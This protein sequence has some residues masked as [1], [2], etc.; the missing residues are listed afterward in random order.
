MN[1]VK[2]FDKAYN[3]FMQGGS[4]KEYWKRRNKLVIEFQHKQGLDDFKELRKDNDVR[5]I[6]GSDK[7]NVP[8]FTIGLIYNDLSLNIPKGIVFEYLD[9]CVEGGELSYVDWYKLHGLD[10][11]NMY[12][13]ANVDYLFE[14][15]EKELDWKDRNTIIGIRNT[16][17]ELNKAINRLTILKEKEWKKNL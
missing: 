16:I 6:F 2:L 8:T 9:Y 10:F 12:L 3:R 1:H 15:K 11:L 13:E 14:L 17:V 4:E 7:F 5:Y